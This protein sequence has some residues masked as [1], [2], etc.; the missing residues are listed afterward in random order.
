MPAEPY[1][2]GDSFHA[3]VTGS[4]KNDEG[5]EEDDKSD[6]ELIAGEMEILFKTLDTSIADVNAIDEWEEPD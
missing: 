5:D 6:I 4:F 3:K 2:W 1:S